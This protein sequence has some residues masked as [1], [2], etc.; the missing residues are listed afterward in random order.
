MPLL[1]AL[2]A[3]IT[4]GAFWYGLRARMAH[5]RRQRTEAQ[6][7]FR[8]REALRHRYISR[9]GGLEFCFRYEP[10]SG[11]VYIE[12][13]PPY[14]ARPTDSHSTHRISDHP[15]FYIC[16]SSPLR[17]ESDA[18]AVAREWAENTVLYIRNGRSF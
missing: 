14:G 5:R 16:W 9:N 7:G 18:F 17:N 6:V 2:A 15:N 13:S 3:W 11:R 4:A 8:S 12:H 1:T 10:Q